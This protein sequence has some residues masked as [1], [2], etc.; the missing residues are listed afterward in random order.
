MTT[1]VV[2]AT[3]ATGR[4]LVEQL[5]KCGQKVRV[6]VRSPD[7]LPASLKNHENLSVIR[8][9]IL[10]LS[11]VEMAQHVRG[12]DAVASCLGHSPSLKGMYGPPRRLVTDATRRLCEAIRA[13]QPKAPVKYVLMNTVG[14]RNRDLDERVSLGQRVVVGLLRLLLPPQVDNEQ[15]ADYLRTKVGQDDG[16][17]EWA[18]VRPDS[19]I[20]RDEVSEYEVHPSPIRS[21]IFDPGSTSRINVA[22][23]MARLITEDDTWDEW[24]GQMPVIYNQAS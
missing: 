8:A 23:W 5:L 7:K 3:G 10:D 20:D 14:N 15:A 11:D 18:A 21:A 19:L 22:H 2:G 24:K 4:L 1:L 16:T 9:S 6:I 13:N 12:C 17:I